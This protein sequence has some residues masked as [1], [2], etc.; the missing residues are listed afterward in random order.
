MTYFEILCYIQNSR[1]VHRIVFIE[2]SERS[3][4]VCGFNLPDA[5]ENQLVIGMAS[6]KHGE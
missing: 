4:Q 2:L 3:S 1:D 6:Q 5:H